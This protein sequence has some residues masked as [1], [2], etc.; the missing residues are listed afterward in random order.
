M[1]DAKDGEASGLHCVGPAAILELLNRVIEEPWRGRG[2]ERRKPPP[3]GGARL[4]PLNFLPSLSRVTRQRNRR[5][6]RLWMCGVP[7]ALHGHPCLCKRRRRDGRTHRS[8]PLLDRAHPLLDRDEDEEAENQSQRS[9]HGATD[10]AAQAQNHR[11]WPEIHAG[12]PASAPMVYCG[13]SR[14]TTCPPSPQLRGGGE[15]NRSIQAVKCPG[16]ARLPNPVSSH[17]NVAR[18]LTSPSESSFL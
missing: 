9:S 13:T 11:P 10:P 1:G 12:V 3:P 4:A 7:D 18:C 5:H 8:R 17:T 16:K 6:E 2:A 14:V 15:P